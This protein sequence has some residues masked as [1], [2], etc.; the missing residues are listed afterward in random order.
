MIPQVLSGRTDNAIKNRWNS[1][2]RRK[3]H[4][5]ECGSPPSP[6]ASCAASSS[7]NA[8]FPSEQR[9]ASPPP[10]KSKGRASI[11]RLGVQK[12]RVNVHQSPDDDKEAIAALTLLSSG[13]GEQGGT[14][15]HFEDDTEVSTKQDEEVLN[16]S[17]SG[18]AGEGEAGKQTVTPIE[19]GAAHGDSVTPHKASEGQWGSGAALARG[20]GEASF[21]PLQQI[22]E[23]MDVVCPRSGLAAPA[24]ARSVIRI[25]SPRN[26]VLLPESQ[27]GFTL[28]AGFHLGLSP[29]VTPSS[30]GI[31]AGS[32]HAGGSSAKL[33]APLAVSNTTPLVKLETA[34]ETTLMRRL[35]F[36]SQQADG[37]VKLAF[38]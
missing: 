12:L 8:A 13:Y 18:T 35:Q 9:S 38:E 28:C 30:S 11:S 16:L 14:P 1:T 34:A 5:L 3:I 6:T 2:I 25:Q 20:A 37:A 31:E 32:S 26:L 7:D 19:E 17:T 21:T 29:L 23:L 4:R 22:G 10:A 36:D 33:Q 24:A 15:D 27:E